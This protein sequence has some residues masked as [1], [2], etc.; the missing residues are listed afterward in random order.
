MNPGAEA[1][2]KAGDAYDARVLAPSPPAANDAPWF[3]DDPVARDG[4]TR[5]VVSPVSSG[6][7][8]WSSLAADDPALAQWCRERWL[9][10]YPALAAAPARLEATR[11][12]L[13]A[14]AEH[15]LK[16]ARE[17]ANGKIGLRWVRGGFGTPFFG[18]DVQVSVRGTELV[19][20][21]GD[22]VERTPLTSLAAAADALGDLL[23]EGSGEEREHASR[24]SPDPLSVDDDA[25]RFIGDWFGFATSV[26]EELR[27]R[28]TE[29]QAPSRVQIWPEHFDAA[30]E[31]GD[32]PAGAR[33]AF[34]CSP[35]DEHH[36][37]PY[38]YVAPWT[39]RPTG[40][41]WNA[42]GFLGAELPYADLLAADDPRA[43]ALDFFAARVEALSS[44]G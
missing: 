21:R 29:M 14:V 23:G 12:G 16:P 20:V 36:P 42:T 26:L 37:E 2:S 5:P 30:L 19:V 25:A 9:G 10:P 18:D 22:A 35:G 31:L 17:K 7:V 13:H 8:L 40:D 6:D 33:A 41:L 43:L 3:A 39:A 34:G 28:A 32:E 4:A 38:L 24:L 15:V 44:T 1:Q 27:A 11:V